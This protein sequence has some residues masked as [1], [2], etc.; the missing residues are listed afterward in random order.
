MPLSPR[1]VVLCLAGLGVAAGVTSFTLSGGS[2]TA[3][4]QATASDRSACRRPPTPHTEG[5]T[6][7]STGGTIA[8]VRWAGGSY[9]VF[10][11]A[12]TGGPAHRLSPAPGHPFPS[13]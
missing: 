11:M 7:Q 6:L 10:V 8:F 1:L 4:S 5:R 2:V 13:R 3:T 12:A 9:A